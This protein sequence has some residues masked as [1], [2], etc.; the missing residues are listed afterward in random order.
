MKEEEDSYRALFAQ[1]R[2]SPILSDLYLN[3]ADVFGNRDTFKFCN[4][5][6]PK[7]MSIPKI[8][9]QKRPNL[10]SLD[11]QYSVV[12]EQ[13]YAALLYSPTQ[14]TELTQLP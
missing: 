3:L 8:L 2:N 4:D 1:D 12:D 7:E 11:G 5:T 6:D 10:A 13:Q 14:Y 9:A